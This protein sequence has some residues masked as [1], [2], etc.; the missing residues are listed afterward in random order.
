MADQYNSERGDGSFGQIENISIDTPT[1]GATYSGKIIN[2]SY[3]SPVPYLIVISGVD[4]NN[5]LVILN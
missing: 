2:Y 5:E 1:D 3:G 4:H